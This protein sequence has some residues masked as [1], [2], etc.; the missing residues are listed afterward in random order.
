M[1]KANAVTAITNADASGNTRPTDKNIQKLSAS[2]DAITAALSA[3]A[4]GADSSPGIPYARPDTLDFA[5]VAHA[6]LP[7]PPA[8][9]RTLP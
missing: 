5:V 6:F 2:K 9:R 1:F 3:T 7:P 8:P 4:R